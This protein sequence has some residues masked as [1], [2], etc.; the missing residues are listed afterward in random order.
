MTSSLGGDTPA[1]ARQRV[2]RWLRQ[3]RG[4]AD[5]TQTDLAQRLGWSL[6]KVQRM[7]TGEVAVS[8]T[9]LRA[10]V[11]LY[12]VTDLDLVATLVKDARL[13]RRERWT[14]SA[15]YRRYLTV[16]LRRLLQFEAVATKIRV[17]QPI[18]IPG[19]LQ[20]PAM[21]DH[22]LGER[23]T[24]LNEDERRVRFEV[25]MRRRADLIERPDAPEYYLV[26]DE[27]VIL[28]IFGGTR[29]AAEQLEHLAEVATRPK[30]FIRII[31]LE[32]SQGAAIRMSGTFVVMNLGDDDADGA[33]LYRELFTADH[34]DHD[35]EKIRSYRNAFEELWKLSLPEDA[36]LRLIRAKAA[37]LRAR[38]DRPSAIVEN[39]PPL[40]P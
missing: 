40:R 38:L 34:I 26:L 22:I 30:V 3:A 7:E 39:N 32:Q 5:L 23:G 29:L 11:E 24:I 16:G 31:P 9:D 2:R 1:V 36:S 33:V 10:T 19:V 35:P 15:E 28:R 13:A 4:E 17:Y 12:G 8:E 18:L 20:T 6:S 14:T 27:S 21:A 37:D 25:R